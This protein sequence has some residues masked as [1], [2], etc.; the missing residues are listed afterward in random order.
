MSRA[1]AEALQAPAEKH[2]RAGTQRQRAPQ[3][4]LARLRPL[5]PE[6][7]ITRLANVTGLDHIG[8]PVWVAIR[9]N[10]RGLSSS[11]GKGL[12]HDCAKVSALMESIENWHA[13]H[14]ALPL[15]RE[16][17]RR[18]A[19]GGAV[20]DIGGLGHYEDAP[21]R[22]DLPI[23]WLQGL[24]LFNGRDTWLP[25]DCVSTSYVVGPG[26]ELGAAF[27]QSSNGLAGGNSLLEATCHALSELIERDAIARS[28]EALR[29]HDAALRVDPDSV[30]D[31]DCRGLLL[32][33]REAGMQFSLLDLTVD[34]GVP[35]YACCIVDAQAQSRW[36]HLPAFNGYGCHL[37]PAIALLRAITEA[38]QSRLT[39]ISG[40][41]DDIFPEDYRRGGHPDE[42]AS[43][44][45]RMG[46]GAPQRHFAERGSQA[47]SDFRA[48]LDALLEALR[49]V[50]L[51]QALVVDLSQPQLGVPVVKAVVPGLAAPTVLL[52]GR[53]VRQGRVWQA[54]DAA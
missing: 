19:Q 17:A 35:V 1:L 10:S 14:I 13:E 8:L 16:S 2:Y 27:V 34:T 53:R 48:D 6:L 22:A 40:S 54:E 24:D 20:A 26:G 37:D 21:P 51:G 5:M 36:R 15:R 50:G 7:G 31:A 4:T 28:N 25:L 29:R 45:A 46:E 9:P 33:L 12:S 49:R 43:L 30:D 42:L 3:E 38:V 41:R 47:G 52:G 32:R 39:H 18:L 11:Q 23:D 44:R